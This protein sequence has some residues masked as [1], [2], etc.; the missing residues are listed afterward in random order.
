MAQS[1]QLV[2]GYDGDLL[3]CVAEPYVAVVQR[4]GLVG[5]L[6]D[7]DSG[8]TVDLTRSDYHADVSSFSVAFVRH[9]GRTL[10][11]AQTAWN[12][13]DMFDPATGE[14]LSPR[15]M[16]IRKV[17]EGYRGAD[18]E[19]I[20]PRYERTN[21]VD[22]FHSLL[23]VS[24]SGTALCSNGWVWSPQD[25]VRAYTTEGFLSG[26]ETSGFR[27]DTTG[28][29]YN[30]DRPCTFVGDDVFVVATDKADPEDLADQ[31]EDADHRP[32]GSLRFLRI[33]RSTPTGQR[34]PDGW[35]F[36]E[37][38][39]PC[40]VLSFADREVEGELWYDQTTGHLLYVSATGAH[41]LDLDGKAVAHRDDI[42]ADTSGQAWHYPAAGWWFASEHGVFYRPDPDSDTIHETS[43]PRP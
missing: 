21:Y 7:M 3:V 42:T 27:A 43:A 9:A 37:R 36:A 29:G 40:D 1:P 10:L 8:A 13:L 6:V 12:R 2:D 18:G 33:D 23:H 39:V 25:Y 38:E 5:V 41:A 34:Y 35:L 32:G 24:P 17:A 26:W 19:R 28:S 22:Y 31:D 14:L 4:Y 20:D 15:T 11:V 30:W 16:S